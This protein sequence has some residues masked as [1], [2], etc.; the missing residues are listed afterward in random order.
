[1][2]DSDCVHFLQWALPRLRLRW[3]GF[4]RV[5]RQVCKRIARR[6]R[7]L[8]LSDLDA[9]RDYLAA[10]PSECAPKRRRPGRRS[11]CCGVRTAS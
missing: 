6:L 10:K 4:R 7:E 8:E 3:S 1:M 9:Y 2:K 11:R 5:R